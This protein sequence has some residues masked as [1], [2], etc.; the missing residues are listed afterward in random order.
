[1]SK[2]IL[3]LCSLAGALLT[4]SVP[5]ALA[6]ARY[7]NQPAMQAALQSLRQ[8]EEALRRADTDKGG[9]RV[10]AL[11]LVNEA[12][13]EV[14]AGIQFDNRHRSGDER[15]RGYGDNR[16]GGD[17]RWRGRLSS[18]DQQ[19]FDSYYSRWLE[20]RRTNNRDEITSMERRMQDVMTHNN[21]P[22][23]VPYDQIASHR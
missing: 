10:K 11:Q 1:M 22:L 6:Q 9:H 15:G 12:Q 8:A 3:A 23:N 14:E 21:I 17:N 19:R 20:Y 4:A 18:D 16:Y 13:R 7:E 5:C 2:N